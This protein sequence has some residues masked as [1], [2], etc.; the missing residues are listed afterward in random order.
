MK[1]LRYIILIVVLAIVSVFGLLSI[2][3]GQHRIISR[4]VDE[5]ENHH[6]LYGP[7]IK[8]QT[9]QLEGR[10]IGVGA[11]LVDMRRA[12]KLVPVYVDV[13]AWVDV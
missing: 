7:R 9:V 4:G 2:P 12:H 5:Y 10:L 3:V 13:Y 11:I 1:R 8:S 6:A